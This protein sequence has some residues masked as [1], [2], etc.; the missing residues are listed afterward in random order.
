M[1]LRKGLILFILLAF[2]ANAVI[3]AKS[4]DHDTVRSLLSSNKLLL[5]GAL[6]VVFLS[7]MCDAGRFCALS[8]AAQ[9]RV[10]FSMGIVLTWLNYFGSAVTPMQSGGGPFQVYVLYK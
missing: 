8:R 9:E 10:P 3:I 5:L 7:W 1:S 6:G 4:V 2:G